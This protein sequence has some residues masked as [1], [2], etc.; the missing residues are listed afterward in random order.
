MIRAPVGDQPSIQVLRLPQKDMTIM[1]DARKDKSNSLE[2]L[3]DVQNAVNTKASIRT[4]TFGSYS[5]L[6]NFQ[7]AVTSHEVLF[8]GLASHFTITRHRMVISIQ[9]K[10]EATAT[11]IQVL[12][13]GNHTQLMASFEGFAHADAM[14]FQIKSSDTFEKVKGDKGSKHSVKLV[15][16]KFTLPKERPDEP[17][18]ESPLA[19]AIDWPTRRKFVNT[20]GLEYA[21]E[22]DD[23]TISFDHEQGKSQ[24]WFQTLD[25]ANMRI[26]DYENFCKAL[27]APVTMGRAFTLKRR[28]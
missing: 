21:E 7:R 4:L 3:R 20:E 17:E 23:I 19:G 9:K 26:Q 28:I 8:D 22:H 11:R 6:H 16:A 25:S 14:I 13:H 1:T 15:E 27:P 2:L 12:S 18:G 24:Q 5:G 10:V